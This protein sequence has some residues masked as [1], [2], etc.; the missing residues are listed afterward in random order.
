MRACFP[1]SPSGSYLRWKNL[2]IVGKLIGA[3]YRPFFTVLKKSSSCLPSTVHV[4]IM[5]GLLQKV[6]GIG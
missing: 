3:H 1:E 6:A 2:F 4:D 5:I